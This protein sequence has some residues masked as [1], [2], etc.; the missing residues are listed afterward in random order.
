MRSQKSVITNLGKI[1]GTKRASKNKIFYIV[2]MSKETIQILQD[3]FAPE[4]IAALIEHYAKSL[5]ASSFGYHFAETA[6]HISCS[7][8]LTSVTFVC[9]ETKKQV[10]TNSKLL[11]KIYDALWRSEY[12][13]Y[14][15]EFTQHSYCGNLFRFEGW[16]NDPARE[17]LSALPLNYD[18]TCSVCHHYFPHSGTSICGI[19]FD[20]DVFQEIDPVIRTRMEM[21]RKKKEEEEIDFQLQG[22]CY[23]PNEDDE[24]NNAAQ[25]KFDLILEKFQFTGEENLI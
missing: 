17:I 21:E 16:V 3:C 7:Y 25:L 9:D 2:D 20:N 23:W 1:S 12:R 18:M 5:S 14:A 6:I 10:K 22:F 19:C 11:Y 24:D 8:R 15:T 13:K 4:P